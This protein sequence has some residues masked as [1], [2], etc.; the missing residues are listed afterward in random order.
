MCGFGGYFVGLTD[1]FMR[2]GLHINGEGAPVFVCVCLNARII[3]NKK[4]ELN[5]TVKDVDSHLIVITESWANKGLT[6][7]I[8]LRRYRLGR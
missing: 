6:R 5:I 8:L 7:Y 4:T 1:L 3:V 2:D